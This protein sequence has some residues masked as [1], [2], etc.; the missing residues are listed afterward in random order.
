MCTFCSFPTN[1]MSIFRYSCFL[2]PEW[3]WFLNFF[4]LFCFIHIDT[5]H[6]WHFLSLMCHRL[7][8]HSPVRCFEFS[9]SSSPGAVRTRWFNDKWGIWGW[10]LSF[11]HLL[12]RQKV[13]E[14]FWD[15]F[16]RH[17]SEA[18]NA[19]LTG[20]VWGLMTLSSYTLGCSQVPLFLDL[21]G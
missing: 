10:D 19:Y 2:N 11:C 8:N 13:I 5:V 4:V 18:G 16:P 15:L 6:V 7:L 3:A 20:L 1:Y 14:P 12:A 21:R 9:V 17:C